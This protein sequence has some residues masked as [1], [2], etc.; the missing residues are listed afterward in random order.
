MSSVFGEI[1]QL[2]F[3]VENIDEAMAF[4]AASLGI[5]PFFIKRNIQFSNYIYPWT[6][7]DLSECIH[8]IGQFRALFK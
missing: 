3:I 2:A 5:G 8:C 4:W 6:I 7:F 1:R